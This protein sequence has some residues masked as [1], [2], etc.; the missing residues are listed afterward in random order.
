MDVLIKDILEFVKQEF[1]SHETFLMSPDDTDYF[2]PKPVTPRGGDFFRFDP[3]KASGNNLHSEI[4]MTEEKQPSFKLQPLPPVKNIDSQ[5][6]KTLV[7][8]V[9][10]HV[11]LCDQIPDD[12]QAKKIANMWKEDLNTADVILLSY[13][14]TAQELK[15]LQNVTQA[16]NHLL[17]PAKYIDA[18]RFEK[19]NKWQLFF[20]TFS[21]KLIIAP[22]RHLWT[23]T[24]LSQF[25]KENPASNLHFLE[26]TPL[27]LLAPI[28]HYLKNPTLKK[29]LWKSIVS[30]LS[31]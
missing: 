20:S 11:K 31:S 14:Q 18:L 22:D 19:E 24:H 13:G 15:F 12:T 3:V 27:L 7:T 21:V 29:Q 9:A 16:I 5:H 4:I 10:P 17:A 8:K 26:K 30:Y 25:Y 1:S 23:K 6:L 2:H 28:S